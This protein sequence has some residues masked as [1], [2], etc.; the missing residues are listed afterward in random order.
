IGFAKAKTD[1]RWGYALGLANLLG[2][3]S[4]DA[5]ALRWP[6]PERA[7]HLLRRVPAHLALIDAVDSSHGS[8]GS[9]VPR[10]LETDTIIGASNVLLADWVGALKMGADPHVSPLN[11]LALD[12]VGLPR[13]WSL[14]GDATP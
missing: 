3:V 10:P 1:E 7:L 4:P 12:Q 9:R 11:D 6:A 5:T 8:S 2:L 13:N 14:H